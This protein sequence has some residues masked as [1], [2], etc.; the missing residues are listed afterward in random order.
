MPGTIDA[1]PTPAEPRRVGLRPARIESLLGQAVPEGEVRAVLG[2]LGFEPTRD[3]A[4]G[5]LIEVSIP[6]FRDG[7]VQREVDLIEEVAR[8]HGLERLPAALPARRSAVGRLTPAQRLRR[9]LEDA[10]RDRGLSEVVAYSFTSVQALRRLRVG[11][12]GALRVRNP[13]SEEGALLRPLLLP[14][15]LDA[16]AHNAAHGHGE[17]ALFESAHVYAAP[18]GPRRGGAPAPHD[19]AG[20][21]SPHG[22][23]PPTSVTTWRAC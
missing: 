20:S 9:R 5:K 23:R 2:R 7:D 19:T 10:L 8:I 21:S 11:E 3:D 16:A 4:D 17:L 1:Y 6:P 13:L 22:A 18:A 15:L 12:G 14:G